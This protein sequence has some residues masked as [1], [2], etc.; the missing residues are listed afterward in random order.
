[1]GNFAFRWLNYKTRFSMGKSWLTAVK[2]QSVSSPGQVLHTA[3]LLPV[4]DLTTLCGWA[5]TAVTTARPH[6]RRA[7]MRCSRAETLK[8]TPDLFLLSHLLKYEL[9]CNLINDRKDYLNSCE[10]ETNH[11]SIQ[12]ACLCIIFQLSRIIEVHRES[13]LQS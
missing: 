7:K 4:S 12:V 8:G 13:G 3:I 10:Q 1:M 5:C 2:M 11:T 6:L 9:F